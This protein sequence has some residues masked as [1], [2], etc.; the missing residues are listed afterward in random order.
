M[1]SVGLTVRWVPLGVSRMR[2]HL[3]QL[4]QLASVQVHAVAVRAVVDVDT[5][6]ID[7][8]HEFVALRAKDVHCFSLTPSIL[9]WLHG[10]TLNE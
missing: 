7:D 3:D 10:W 5:L 1:L 9:R 4:L 8:H 2:G 6:A